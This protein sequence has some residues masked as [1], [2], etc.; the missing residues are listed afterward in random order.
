MKLQW[1]ASFIERAGGGEIIWGYIDGTLQ[2]IC[3]PTENQRLVYFGHKHRHGFKYQAIVTLDG[4][5]FSVYGSIIGSRGDWFL[6]QESGLE[7]EINRLF[8]DLSDTERL[9][10][11]GDSAYTGSGATM[12]AYKKFR[13]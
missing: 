1:Y 11:Y 10:V 3:R 6:F 13:G 4:L 7:I 9:Y 5:F 12:G 8:D 2:Q